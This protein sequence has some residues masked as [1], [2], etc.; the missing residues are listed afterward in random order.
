M[1]KKR[2]LKFTHVV[3]AW[4][5]KFLAV[6]QEVAYIQMFS[7]C[8][9]SGRWFADGLS[10]MVCVVCILELDDLPPEKHQV[11]FQILYQMM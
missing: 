8:V 2:H 9:L 4:Y 7:T 11:L 10:L 1:R 3:V 5:K 6:E